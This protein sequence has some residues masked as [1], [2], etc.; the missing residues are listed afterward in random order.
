[1]A[2]T[3]VVPDV[4]TRT[5]SAISTEPADRCGAESHAWLVGRSK[6]EIPVPVDLRNRRVQC[7]SCDRGPAI[8]PQRLN[9]YYNPESGLVEQ[10]ACG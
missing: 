4:P 5:Y 7:T 8:I 10:V 9:I 2:D 1:M 6:T 3:Y